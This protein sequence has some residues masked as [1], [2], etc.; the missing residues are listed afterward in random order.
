MK[1]EAYI[2]IET[3]DKYGQ[4]KY[5]YKTLAN[6]F[7][8][9]FIDILYSNAAQT[10][11]SVKDT[12]NTLR[13]VGCFAGSTGAWQWF[14]MNEGAG[15][16][17]YGILVGTGTNAVAITDYALQTQIA[18][19]TSSGQLQY[20]TNSISAPATV[21]TSRQFTVSRTFTNVSGGNITINEVGLA[22]TTTG[23]CGITYKYLIDRTLSTFTITNGYSS[24]VTYT[25]KVTV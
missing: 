18:N 8:L 7:V 15:A 19:G 1:L 14:T 12:S 4:L 21:S 16:A 20:G 10:T 6:S 17:T 24:T 22:T 13:T 2:Q 11:Q 3:K 9:A 23:G 5:F 25:I